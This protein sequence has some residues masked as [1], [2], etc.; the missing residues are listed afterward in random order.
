LY[1]LVIQRRRYFGWQTVLR[2]CRGD[3]KRR[4]LSFKTNS[5]NHILAVGT[6]D[7]KARLGKLFSLDQSVI[8]RACAEYFGRGV[9]ANLC[10]YKGAKDTR[11]RQAVGLDCGV[12]INQSINKHF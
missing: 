4:P 7:H 1:A 10:G 11:L 8:I 2:S 5:R 9:F 6:D 3:G 12:A